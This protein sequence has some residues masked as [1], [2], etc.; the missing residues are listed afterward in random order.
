M[1]FL[2]F[3]TGPLGKFAM[4]GAGVVGLLLAGA[5]W[6][7]SHDNAVRAAMQASADKAIAAQQ[8]V[9]HQ[10]E[11]DALAAVA[12][13]AAARARASSDLRSKIHALPPTASCATSPAVRS[14]LDGLRNHSNGPRPT[15]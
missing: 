14:L 8:T 13:D 11:V 3:L 5:L 2:A 9:D 6:L 15:P 12:A 4:I 1:P 10:H 7:H